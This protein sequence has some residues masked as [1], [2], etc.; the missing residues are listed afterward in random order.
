[1]P[2]YTAGTITITQGSTDLFGVWRTTVTGVAGTFSTGATLNFDSTQ[3]IGNVISWTPGTGSLKFKI[4]STDQ[5][6]A[7]EKAFTTAATGTVALVDF[8]PAF[9]TNV[10]QGS[11]FTPNIT[12]PVSYLISSIPT[13][14]KVTLTAPYGGSTLT[15]NAYQITDS[16]T[17]SFGFPY[18][19]PG[20]QN[21]TSIIKSGI[22]KIDQTLNQLSVSGTVVSGTAGPP[23]PQGVPGDIQ[24]YSDAIVSGTWQFR[25]NLTLD[26]NADTAYT[27]TIDSGNTAAQASEIALADRGAIKW[28]FGKNSS[29]NFFIFDQVKGS[30]PFLIESPSSA[31]AGNALFAT[32]ANGNV[33]IGTFSAAAKLQVVGSGIINNRLFVGHTTITG[34]PALIASST[35]GG[36]V[37]PRMNN[38][39][40]DAISTAGLDPGT[41]IW[42]TTSGTLN[43]WNGSAWKQATLF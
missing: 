13:R 30:T 10:V 16:F 15:D 32:T 42:N 11:V 29:Q 14:S 43:V 25:K 2:K 5:P 41:I 23:G 3:A 34:T 40:K 1:M 4:T 9:N 39:Q 26:N 8:A 20:D 38:T 36:F 19:E 22:I 17:P 35:T 18:A 31:S 6:R 24:A 27:M 28:F 21:P 33:G 7:G 12:S 37:P